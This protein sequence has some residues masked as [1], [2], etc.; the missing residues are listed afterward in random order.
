MHLL[1]FDVELFCYKQNQL[2]MLQTLHNLQ[3]KSKKIDTNIYSN[4]KYKQIS[5]QSGKI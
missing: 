2:N 1:S 3:Y 4:L 5:N